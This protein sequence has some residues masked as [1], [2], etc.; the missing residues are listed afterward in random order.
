MWRTIWKSRELFLQLSKLAAEGTEI[1]RKRMER[2][3]A[4]KVSRGI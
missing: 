2:R 4:D 1:R 3:Q